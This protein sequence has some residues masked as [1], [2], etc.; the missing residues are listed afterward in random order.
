MCFKQFVL[1][2]SMLIEIPTYIQI[3]VQYKSPGINLT[4][5]QAKFGW[6]KW[7]NYYCLNQI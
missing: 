7:D 5:T 1:K 2:I 6:I 4:G 3:T